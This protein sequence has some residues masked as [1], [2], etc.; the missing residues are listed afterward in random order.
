MNQLLLITAIGDIKNSSI[1][2][3]TRTVQEHQCVIEKSRVTNIGNNW[4]LIA[5][6]NGQWNHITK[7]ELDLP[8]LADRDH[9]T[10]NCQRCSHLN[11]EH[12]MLPYTI[13]IITQATDNLLH[14]ICS[15]L[16]AMEIIILEVFT[17]SKKRATS[18]V[19]MDTIVMKIYIPADTQLSDLR[20]QFMLLC[21]EL[22][23]DALLEPE[24]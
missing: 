3:I 1:S 8:I 17:Q 15:F 19:P 20:E 10:I 4:A 18:N 23:V 7:L 2:A 22:N 21:D 13:E 24:K 16:D 12:D 9:L 6:V 11:F 14:E 5:Q